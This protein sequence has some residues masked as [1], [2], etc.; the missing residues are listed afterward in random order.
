MFW[1]QIW[2][3]GLLVFQQNLISSASLAMEIFDPLFPC[4]TQQ[5]LPVSSEILR[6][7]SPSPTVNISC[8]EGHGSRRPSLLYLLEILPLPPEAHRKHLWVGTSLPTLQTEPLILSYINRPF[9]SYAS[10]C[11]TVPHVL[12]ARSESNVRGHL[13]RLLLLNALGEFIQR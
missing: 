12:R 13:L 11:L 6:A 10:P 9:V 3:W 2:W 5:M 1:I 7:Q 4:E 8:S